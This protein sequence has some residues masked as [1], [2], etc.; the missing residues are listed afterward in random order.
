MSHDVCLGD[1]CVKETENVFQVI[2]DELENKSSCSLSLSNR[3]TKHNVTMF[4]ARLL[5]FSIMLMGYSH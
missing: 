2:R 3:E 4:I 1:F 5:V